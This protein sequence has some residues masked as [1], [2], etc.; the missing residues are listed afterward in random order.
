[1][2]GIDLTAYDSFRQL[3]SRRSIRA[4]TFKSNLEAMEGVELMAASCQLGDRVL[5]LARGGQMPLHRAGVLLLD[6]VACFTNPIEHAGRVIEI[7]KE[8]REYDK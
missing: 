4:P 7:G 1:M 6:L 5:I 2:P 3:I 8:L